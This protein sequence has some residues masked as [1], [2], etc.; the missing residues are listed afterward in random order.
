MQQV[1]EFRDT[2]GVIRLGYFQGFTDRGGTD[3]SYFFKDVETKALYVVSGTRLKEAKIHV[4]NT[5]PSWR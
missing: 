4:T 2:A 5:P 3:V 1:W